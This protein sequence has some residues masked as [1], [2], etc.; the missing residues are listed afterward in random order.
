MRNWYLKIIQSVLWL[1]LFILC[2]LL[3]RSFYSSDRIVIDKYSN[4]VVLQC[5]EGNI[6]VRVGHAP[7][8]ES[9]PALI[10]HTA[11]ST[12]VSPNS[13]EDRIGSTESFKFRVEGSSMS[14]EEST[15]IV[16]NVPILVLVLLL[17]I[18][19]II[20]RYCRNKSSKI[21]GTCMVCGYDLR[22]TPERCPECGTTYLD[23]RLMENPT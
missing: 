2:A 17:I 6:S 12:N 3:L 11:V 14:G 7:N 4:W 15:E 1:G 18:M 5:G 20:L 9:R 16:I 19:M 8:S 22:A 21:P 23:S 13:D 10:W